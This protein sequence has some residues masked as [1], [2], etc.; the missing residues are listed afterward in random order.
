MSAAAAGSRAGRQRGRGR[1]APSSRAAVASVARRPGGGSARPPVQLRRAADP[2]APSRAASRGSR[3]WA[4]AARA[5]PCLRVRCPR[6]TVTPAAAALPRGPGAARRRLQRVEIARGPPPPPLPAQP[7]ITPAGGFPV[8]VIAAIRL[9]GATPPV[10]RR[11][12]ATPRSRLARLTGARPPRR[13]PS[14]PP[15]AAC[16][17]SRHRALVLADQPVQRERQRP[18]VALAALEPHPR[19]AGVELCRLDAVE[20]SATAAAAWPSR[21]LRAPGR[22]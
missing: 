16:G 6:W 17:S 19:R 13:S 9:W 11:D 22:G 21:R 12:V 10:S 14:G 4:A 18:P 1:R 2:S 8:A 7:A 20:P 15:S 5:R 3:R